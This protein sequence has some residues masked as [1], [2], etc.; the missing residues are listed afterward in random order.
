MPV[1]RYA[2]ADI[3]FAYV[4]EGTGP[5]VLLVHGF[6]LDRTMWD[7]QAAAL[8]TDF[9]VLAPDLRGFGESGIGPGDADDGVSMETY[10]A[11]LVALLDAA[12]VS[13][14]VVLAGFSMGGYVGWQFALQHVDRLRALVACDTRAIADTDEAAAN[15]ESMATEVLAADSSAAAEGMIPK[16]IAP[17]TLEFGGPAVA[18]L[19]EMIG[20][21]TPAGIAAAQRGMAVRPDVRQQLAEIAVPA[22]V[23]V[24]EEDAI[25]PPTEMAEIAAALPDAT[26]VE[27]PTAG[28]MSPL[29]NPGDFNAALL[30][31]LAS[32]S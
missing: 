25:S 27:I 30:D 10:A 14:P 15:R 18:R 6:P 19:M 23:V 24:G 8:S 20:R 28:H 2:H 29:E 13:E 4:D 11:D 17:R 7:A 22:L 1:K 26:F 21:A 16:L 31:F 9:R 5:P 3:D 12:G 32:L